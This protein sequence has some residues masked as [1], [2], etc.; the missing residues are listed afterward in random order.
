MRVGILGSGLMGGKL[1]T[2]FARAGHDVVFSYAR[3]EQKLKSLAREA[4]GKARAGT[5]LGAA[6]DADAVL[7]VY[8]STLSR[9]AKKVLDDHLVCSEFDSLV[10]A[11][12]D[13]SQAD[14]CPFEKLVAGISNP[15]AAYEEIKVFCKHSQREDQL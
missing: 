13:I 2:I 14:M 1:G 15:R 7:L 12:L 3:S 9:E 5:P 8:A 11:I 6:Q 10:D 4:G